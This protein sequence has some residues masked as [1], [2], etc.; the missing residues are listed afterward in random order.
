MCGTRRKP[1]P[2]GMS[3]ANP[4][5]YQREETKMKYTNIEDVRATVISDISDMLTNMGFVYDGFERVG[6]MDETLASWWRAED[7][8]E[9]VALLND[10]EVNVSVE[11]DCDTLDSWDYDYGT[12]ELSVKVARMVDNAAHALQA[13]ESGE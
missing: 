2:L 5:Y 12:K 8:V 10:Y 9:V 1:S 11:T 3:E 13:E 7:D 4:Y 6:E